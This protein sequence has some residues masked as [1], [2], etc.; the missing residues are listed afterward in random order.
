M[1][2]SGADVLLQYQIP[3]VQLLL[4]HTLFVVLLSGFLIFPHLNQCGVVPFF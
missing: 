2:I 1:L 4:Y 3:D